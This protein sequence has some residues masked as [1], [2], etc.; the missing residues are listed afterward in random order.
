MRK[1]TLSFFKLAAIILV[2][3]FTTGCSK[4]SK[5][6]WI[7]YDE[8]NCADKWTFTNNNEVLKENIVDYM[9]GKGVKIFEIEIFSLAQAESCSECSCKTGRQVKC[10][11]KK[12][13]LDNAK[14]EGFYE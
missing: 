14:S 12:G 3:L 10:K 11:I 7:L 6:R 4:S 13:D 2:V 5:M 8:T 1:S 9:E